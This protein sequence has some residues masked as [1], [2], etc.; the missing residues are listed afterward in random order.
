MFP[1]CLDLWMLNITIKS[2]EKVEK[3]K[4]QHLTCGSVLHLNWMTACK[5][6]PCIPLTVY[7]CFCPF[8]EWGSGVLDWFWKLTYR[9]A[10]PIAGQSSVYVSGS[11][12]VKRLTLRFHVT[13]GHSVITVQTPP[14]LPC[15]P[16]WVTERAT[17]IHHVPFQLSCSHHFAPPWNFFFFS[18]FQQNSCFFEQFGKFWKTNGFWKDIG[19]IVHAL[20][21]N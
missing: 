3:I 17:V 21:C 10:K 13:P 7:Y 19:N 20:Y 2:V 18:N 1:Q 15:R 8:T 6:K 4:E 5:K 11:L 16:L 9:S 12:W 14:W